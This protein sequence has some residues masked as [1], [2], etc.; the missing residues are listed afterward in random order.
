MFSH[1]LVSLTGNV[2]SDPEVRHFESGKCKANFSVALYAG[3]DR[4]SEWFDVECWNYV[5]KRV[6]E[7]VAKGARVSISGSLKQERW[8]TSEGK[9]RS[10]VVVNAENVDL[11]AKTK[12][13]APAGHYEGF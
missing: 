8:Q 1:N 9:N 2:G 6:A 12:T 4:P 10:K 5:A 11:I 13:A 3:K 7:N